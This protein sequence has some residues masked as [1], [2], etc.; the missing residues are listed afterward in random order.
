[1]EADGKP[2]DMSVEELAEMSKSQYFLDS[3]VENIPLIIYVKE[4]KNLRFVRLNR[5]A[6]EFYGYSRSDWMGKSAG[7]LFPVAEA[8]Y[9]TKT[10]REVLAGGLVVDI[11][12]E[13]I[14]TRFRGRR[15]VQMKKIPIF[16]NEG[17]PIYIVAIA[18]DIT[19]RQ[20]LERALAATAAGMVDT[21]KLLNRN[22]IRSGLVNQLG[23]LL[24]GC[25]NI[26]EACAVIAHGAPELFPGRLGFMSLLNSSDDELE[27]AATW[28]E[29]S[30]GQTVFMPQE[31][32]ALRRGRL[33]ISGETGPVCGHLKGATSTVCLC[34]PMFAQG[35]VVGALHIWPSTT[36]KESD[37]EKSYD[38]SFQQLVLSVSEH[39][40]MAVSN[41]R[42]RE[43]LST[44]SIRD[45]LT[46][47]FNRRYLEETLNR[48]ITLATRK[49]TEFGVVQAD[50]DNFK[51]FN[52]THG[53][54]A[55]DIALKGIAEFLMS[56]VRDN[57]VVCRYGG[58]ELTLIFPGA[59]LEITE[60]RAMELCRRV[61]E[62]RLMYGDAP[63]SAPTM[64]FGVAAF[65]INGRSSESLL[66]ASDLALYQAKA[67]GRDKVVRAQPDP[68]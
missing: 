48:E 3:I 24:D 32:W 57:D 15:I 47:L 21:I 61:K 66:R 10:D 26:E 65:P 58:E 54:I 9:Y 52:D 64:S 8:D 41:F 37:S 42:L 17:K 67:V 45:P 14:Q 7:E 39:V 2:D 22:S 50:I 11:P 40:G 51:A 38:Q 53:H 25:I 30:M 55:G 28:G 49:G 27:L 5:A 31:C 1:M 63:L 12:E 13:P 46:N 6:E 34:V 56:S 59:S 33:H 29:G 20:E 36:S 68:D 16:D 23:V 19:D 35:D 44:M 43:T 18:E 62:V 4:A 60:S